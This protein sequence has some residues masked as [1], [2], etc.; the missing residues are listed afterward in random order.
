M[1]AIA[2]NPIASAAFVLLYCIAAFT[3]AYIFIKG[4]HK[5]SEKL[6]WAGWV[7]QVPVVG[8]LA[9]WICYLLQRKDR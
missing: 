5:I 6:Y 8:A 2:Q 9:Y 3:A 4:K 7:L 1:Q